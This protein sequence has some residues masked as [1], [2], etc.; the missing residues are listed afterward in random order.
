ML[1][2]EFQ[3]KIIAFLVSQLQKVNSVGQIMMVHV[4]LW[5]VRGFGKR[6]A[7]YHTTYIIDNVDSVISSYTSRQSQTEVSFIWIGM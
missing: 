3:I 6:P 1:Y 7:M 2:N 5:L 4:N